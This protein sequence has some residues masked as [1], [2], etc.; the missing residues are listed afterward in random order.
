MLLLITY[1]VAIIRVCVGI[2]LLGHH[3]LCICNPNRRLF[4]DATLINSS[5]N[6]KPLVRYVV[7][8]VLCFHYLAKPS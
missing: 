2:I 5:L 1:Y 4:I 7:F 6:A 3:I 8:T